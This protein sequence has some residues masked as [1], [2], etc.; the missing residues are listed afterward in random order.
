MP[1]PLRRSGLAALVVAGALLIAAPVASAAPFNFTDWNLTGSL[2]V[3]K[4]KQ[5]IAFPAGSKFN[6]SLELTNGQLTGHVTVP[7]FSTRLKVL[8]LPVDATLQLVEAQPVAGTVT[9]GSPNITID[10]TTAATLRIT[11]LSSPLV[12]LNL[13]G[14]QCRTS[15]PVVLPL[16]YVGPLNLSTGF[17]F[18]GTTTIPRL[19]HCGLATPLLNQL[20]AGSGNAFTATISPPA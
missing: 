19:T 5:S 2:T 1:L 11:R 15:E 13:V 8:G 16:H 10:A 20:M 4:L 18:Q 14:N 12:P 3:A 17:T 9:F 6:G 7:Q